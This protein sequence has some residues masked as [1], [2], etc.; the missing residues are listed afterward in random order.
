MRDDPI[1]NYVSDDEDEY[2]QEEPFHYEDKY[3]YDYQWYHEKFPVAWAVNHKEGT[4]PGQCSNCADYGSINGVF[5]GYC[6]NCATC[7]Y[8]GTRGRGFIEAGV[9]LSENDVLRF[10]SAFE[11]YLSGVN[12]NEILPIPGQNNNLSRVPSLGDI[13]DYEEPADEHDDPTSILN[14]HFEG[15]YNDW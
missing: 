6:A 12:L 8:E 14:A 5:I 2:P 4:G 7:D 13:S 3:L 15:G 1:W 9:E 11:T 10:E